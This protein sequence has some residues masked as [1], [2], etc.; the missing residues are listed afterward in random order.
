MTVNEI[1][2][3][4]SLVVAFLILESKKGCNGCLYFG[5]G[6]LNIDCLII[7]LLYHLFIDGPNLIPIL[8]FDVVCSLK[9]LIDDV[10]I[11]VSKLHD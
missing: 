11:I 3:N 5:N 9:E 2:I 10:V 1:I 6:L 8:F 4:H 7:E